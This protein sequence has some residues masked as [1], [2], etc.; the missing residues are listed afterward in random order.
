MFKWGG[1][2]I[3]LALAHFCGYTVGPRF[4]DTLGERLLSTKSGCLILLNRGQ[5]RLY[6]SGMYSRHYMQSLYNILR[7]S[8]EIDS[9]LLLKYPPLDAIL[10]W[11][12]VDTIMIASDRVSP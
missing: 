8:L 9:I 4:R 3:C 6:S 1:Y 7:I 10:S 5:I 2:I 11:S 12:T